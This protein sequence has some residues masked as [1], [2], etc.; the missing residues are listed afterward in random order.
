MACAVLA[1]MTF[2]VA[3]I[4]FGSKPIRQIT[5]PEGDPFVIPAGL[6]CAF[7]VG[8]TP[9]L[10]HGTITQYSDGRI[11][12]RNHA[13]QTLTNLDTGASYQH[14]SRYEIIER[15]DAN[16]L[17]HVTIN[18][19]FLVQFYPGDQGPFGTVG[20]NGALY[21]LIGHSEGTLDLNADVVTS[22]KTDGQAQ[23]VCRILA[24]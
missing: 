22:W 1:A 5:E 12:T 19:T 23:D 10:D 9:H 15:I 8:G 17:D 13:S 3:P 2:V 20:E 14:Y 21:G 6:G 11:V 18:G 24:P 7:P 4:A 16:N